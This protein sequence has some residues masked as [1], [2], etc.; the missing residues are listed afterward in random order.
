MI[1][2]AG[3]RIGPTIMGSDLPEHYINAV[4][5]TVDGTKIGI[6]ASVDGTSLYDATTGD[7]IDVPALPFTNTAVSPNGIGVGST[8]DGHLYTFDPDTLQILDQSPGCTA[9]RRPSS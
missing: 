4:W 7:R 3:N 5:S 6:S 9:S 8:V 2:Q 1:D